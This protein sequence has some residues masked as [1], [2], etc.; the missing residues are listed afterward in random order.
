MRLWSLHPE[1]LDRQGL[2]ACWREALL[3][4]AVLAGRTRG[5][6][7]H[8]QLERFRAQPDPLAAIGAYLEA[9]AAAAGARGY[10]F[11][12]ARIERSGAD[13]AAPVARVPV[14]DGQLAFE[15]QHLRAKLAARSPETPL[16]GDPVPH[17]LFLVESGPV[18]G[19]E[20]AA[21]AIPTE[22]EQHLAP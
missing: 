9:V 11:D 5:Y 10:R 2:T 13:V 3:A 15:L 6:T 14:T 19:W 21:T 12:R 20:R 18:A 22:S 17:P 1:L 16:P 7:R 4:Q 8:P